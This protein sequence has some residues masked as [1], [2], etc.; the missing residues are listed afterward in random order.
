MSSCKGPRSGETASHQQIAPPPAVRRNLADLYGSSA[1]SA[2]DAVQLAGTS[3]QLLQD[4]RAF[5]RVPKAVRGS[6]E[7]QVRERNLEKR[8]RKARVWGHVSD[9]QEAE[10]AELRAIEI[11]GLAEADAPPDPLDPFADDAANRLEQDLLMFSNGIRPRALLRRLRRY[12][13]YVADPALQSRPEVQKYRE[14]VQLTCASA[15]GRA[16]YVAGQDI[17]GDA[18]RTFA[19]TPEA[20]GPLL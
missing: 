12:Q 4:I 1:S 15:A 8:L 13:R 18:L 20:C 7:A 5:G 14:Q 11:G 3:E 17:Q 6:S 16:S 9:A 19:C 10:L 2:G